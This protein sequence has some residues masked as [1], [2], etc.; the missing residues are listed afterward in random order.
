M[1]SFFMQP[2]TNSPWRQET[3]SVHVLCSPDIRVFGN[4]SGHFQEEQ[5]GI[6]QLEHFSNGGDGA[7][8]PVSVLTLLTESWVTATDRTSSGKA[9]WT[10]F[11]SEVPNPKAEPGCGAKSSCFIYYTSLNS[12][13]LKNYRILTITFGY[14]SIVMNVKMLTWVK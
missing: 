11:N 9:A 12:L 4:Q 6:S 8:E 10:Q 7:T 2:A 5:C 3:V 1:F 14:N 13:L